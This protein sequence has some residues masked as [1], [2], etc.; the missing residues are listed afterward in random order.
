MLNWT[1]LIRI[2]N[3]GNPPPDQRIEKSEEEWKSLLTNE[4]FQI[5]RLKEQ[6]KQVQVNSVK[7]MNQAYMVAFVV[8]LLCSIHVRNLTQALVGQVLRSQ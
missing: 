3:N 2:A 8:P 4:Q 1:D 5:T 7:G 6:K